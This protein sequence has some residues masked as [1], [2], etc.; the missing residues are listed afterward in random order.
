MRVDDC[1]VLGCLGWNSRTFAHFPRISE[2]GKCRRLGGS[3]R[4]ISRSWRFDEFNPTNI[5]RSARSRC[6][7]IESSSAA[8]LSA[9]T[10]VSCATSLDVTSTARCTSPSK[11]GSLVGGVTYV[12]RP[13][14]RMSEFTDPDAAGIRMLAV[15]PRHQGSGAGRALT[16]WCIEVGTISRPQTRRAALDAPMTVAH[17]IYES[18][19]FVRSPEHTT[20]GLRR[21]TTPKS[22]C[23]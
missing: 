17:G 23:T 7:R 15:D 9:P 21:T 14:R 11:N 20:S 5:P 2:F 18:L 8:D 3:P 1:A 4:N 19:G 6:A 10:K 13:G 16:A 22:R 12:P